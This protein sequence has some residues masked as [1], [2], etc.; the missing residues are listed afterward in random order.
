MTKRPG[1]M[2]YFTL[3]P[4]LERLSNEDKGILF[5]AI[6]SYGDIGTTPPLPDTL[7][8]LW[9]LIQSHLLQDDLRYRQTVM[10]RTYAAYVRWAKQNMEVVKPYL[11]WAEEK[12][13]SPYLG[14]AD[15]YT[16]S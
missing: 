9:P 5:D 2:I 10:K 13:Y 6:L 7:Y 3:R 14:E 11:V 1:V 4:V 8:T 12:G 15:E 16:L